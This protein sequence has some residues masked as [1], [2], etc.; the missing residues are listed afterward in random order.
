LIGDCGTGAD[1]FNVE[2]S[3]AVPDEPPPAGVSGESGVLELDEHASVN[4]RSAAAPITA[5]VFRDINR[6]KNRRYGTRWVV[7]DIL[8]E[9]F[10]VLKINSLE[11]MLNCG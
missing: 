3:D 1:T 9:S 2:P 11:I 6:S 7:V 5:N 8:A 4:P 10:S